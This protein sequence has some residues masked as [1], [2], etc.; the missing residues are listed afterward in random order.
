MPIYI[1][2]YVIYVQSIF[3]LAQHLLFVLYVFI[4]WV[5]LAILVIKTW[6]VCG[7]LRLRIFFGNSIIDFV[8]PLSIKL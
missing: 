4:F 1:H 2:M 6:F 7:G 5:V 8:Q 3:D